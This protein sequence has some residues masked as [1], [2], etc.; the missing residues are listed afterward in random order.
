MPDL[1]KEI[2]PSILQT[3]KNFIQSELDEKQ[4]PAFMV[5]RALSQYADTVLYANLINCYS[6]LDNK[7]KNDFFLNTIKPCKRPFKK[8]AKRVELVDLEV[9]KRYYG[10]NDARALEASKILSIDQ[11]NS[12]RKELETGE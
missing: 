10:Y 3:K 2:L 12:L 5:N 4:Y 6:N 11:I 9:I 8:W 1:F 7:L